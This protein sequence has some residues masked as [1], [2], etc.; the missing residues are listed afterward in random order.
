METL[1]I[2]IK[3]KLAVVTLDRGRANAINTTMLSEL[4]AVV[5]DLDTDEKVAG[6]VITGKENF[7]SAGVD[8]IE[9]Y[10]YNEAQSK[11]FWHTLLE[12]VATLA[13]FKKPFV[14]AIT[15][16]SP[17]GGC[18]IALCSDYR[19]MA[20]GEYIIGLNEVPVGII[21]PEAIFH[22]YAF[23]LGSRKAYQYLLEGKLLKA[24]A[25]LADGLV[26]ELAEPAQVFATAEQK[27]RSYM[28]LDPSTWQQTKLNIRGE[29]L[30]KLQSD[31]QA[32][33]DKMLAQ[34]WSPA[35]RAILKKMIEKLTN[36]VK[37]N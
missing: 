27:A 1:R 7:F 19:V 24:D 29:L 2:E 5:K 35:T 25:A 20:K 14:T 26:D 30:A 12:T 18:V 28:K 21:V 32:T 6:L 31:N 15:G 22:L 37:A 13:A 8:L 9:L 16:H 23:W 4:I 10:G 11:E 34:W 33:L 3:D 17:A 36:P